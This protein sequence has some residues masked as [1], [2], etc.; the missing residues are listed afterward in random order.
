M[1]YPLV[2][3][4]EAESTKERILLVAVRLFSINGYASVSMRD[5]ASSINIKPA[6]IYNH[7]ESKEALFGAIIDTIKSVYMDFYDRLGRNVRKATCFTD[8][9]ECLF[10]E[11]RD[12]YHMLIYYGITLIVTEQYRN[13][14][15]RI[16][17]N[18][19]FMK[20]GI[21]YSA[22]LFA[23]SIAKGWVKDFDTKALATFFMNSICVGSLIRTQQALNNPTAYDATEMFASLQEFMLSSVEVIK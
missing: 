18:D 1:K 22:K 17:F 8:V 11:L 7:F 15:A 21:D 6:S 5:I 12:V 4:E 20:M 2:D 14:R 16:A 23:D 9:I 10:A 13:E 19:I 3:V